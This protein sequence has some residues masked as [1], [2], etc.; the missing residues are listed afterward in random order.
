MK[1]KINIVTLGCS[2]NVVDSEKLLGSLRLAGYSIGWDP[3]DTCAD[4]VIIN[5]CG[6]I[7]DAKEESI[8]TILRFV[9]AKKSGSV[10][11]LY[12]M[13]CLSQRYKDELRRE[14][15]E[16]DSYFGVN[17]PDELLEK[18]G[19]GCI[20]SSSNNRI[21]TN[22]GHYAYLKISEGCNRSCSFCAIPSIRG[23]YTSRSLEDLEDEAEKL[24]DLGVKE[25]ILVAQDLGYYGLDLYGKRKLPDLIKNLL[26]TGNFSWIR[27]HYLYPDYFP[28][29]IIALM[30]D[31]QQIC[32]YIDIPIQH[33]SEKMLRLMKRSYGRRELEDILYRLKE[34]LPDAAFRTTLISGHP[35]ET[36][37]DHRE[38]L[39]F[40][41]QFRFDRLGVFRYSHEE[42]TY[43]GDNFKDS[44]S[45]RIKE[46]RV[47]ELM[48]IQQSISLERNSAL[49]GRTMKVLIDRK[50]NE[51][52]TGRTE[53]DSP[54]VDQEILVSVKY[55]LTPGNFYDIRIS[56]SA[57][58]D[59]IGIPV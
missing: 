42:G 54:E 40:V 27:L 58:F 28:D 7:N 45:E 9:N 43:S 52:Y 4:T 37:D 10:R 57:E 14:I 56:R 51:F 18:T 11:N 25:I 23:R 2:K 38:M 46:S 55:D 50:E 29:E 36:D 22:P 17:N 15:P 5:T 47:S 8:D 48:A 30:R 34:Q 19:A 16:V 39:E 1:R 13:G 24:A 20:G 21:L 33:V 35:G 59:L 49:I 3:E 31:N 32:R 12:V 26:K 6:F 44:I 41:K 53:H